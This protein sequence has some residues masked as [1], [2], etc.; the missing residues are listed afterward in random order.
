MSS[1]TSDRLRFE[2]QAL[3]ENENTWGEDR[4]NNALR[5]LEEGASGFVEVLVG[6]SNVT[7]TSTVW[8]PDAAEYR[9]AVIRLETDTGVGARNI[10][11]PAAQ[12]LWKFHNNTAYTQTVKTA[13]GTGATLTAGEIKSIY[14]D[15]TDCYADT[16]NTSGAQDAATAAA[17]SATSA[18]TSATAAAASATEAAAVV[19]PAQSAPG[20]GV[21][22]L[23][24][25]SSP[26]AV[27]QGDNGY[28]LA[29]NCTGGAITITLP[30]ISGISTP[31]NILIKKTDVTT[32]AVTINRSGSDTFDD[33]S[34]SL[35][36]TTQGMATWI[37][38]EGA[39]WYS[40]DTGVVTEPTTS[41]VWVGTSAVTQITPNI[42]FDSL[43]PVSSSGSGAFAPDL[44]TGVSFIRTLTGNS[45]LSAPTNG[46]EGQSLVV[47]FVQDATGSR[48]LSFAGD[49]NFP[50]GV[51]PSP[52]TAAAAVDQLV[53]VMRAS[54]QWDCT[55]NNGLA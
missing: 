10:I 13:S 30:A 35:S 52:S 22:V 3:G 24:S 31:F 29:C 2:I 27:V 19:A 36:L 38:A 49:Y 16:V 12:R 42:L 8:T 37:A 21:T 28:F 17:A 51:T 11:V 4:L 40:M 26:R 33:A 47:W 53:C 34:T 23:T 46:K 41:Q 18:A 25:A 43:V 7:L 54:G 50:L 1:S 48:T 5:C 55:Y 44:N 20:R 39:I 32:N 9:N 45:S 15:A 14:C 6:A